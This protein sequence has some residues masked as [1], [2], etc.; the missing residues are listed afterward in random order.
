M[1]AIV[2]WYLYALYLRLLR[3]RDRLFRHRSLD[4]IDSNLANSLYM[5]FDSVAGAIPHKER[6]RNSEFKVFSQHGEDGILAYIFSDI[7]V[8]N[9]TFLEFGITDGR[10]CNTAN[11]SINFGWNGL[12]LE[13]D[14]TYAR[15]ARSYYQSIERYGGLDVKVVE[16]FVTKENIND[17]ITSN[18]M[19]GEIDLLSIDIDGNDYWIWEQ[20]DVISPRVVVMEYNASFGRKP[21]SVRYDPE[22]SRFKKHRSGWYHGASLAAL[23]NLGEKKGYDL[24]CADCSGVNGFFLRKDIARHKLEV[25]SAEEAFYPQEKRLKVATEEQQFDVIKHLEYLEM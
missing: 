7:G 23:A 20:I 18:G 22:F 4:T 3:F 14:P 12:L 6:I 16:C 17:T 8:T 10:E 9:K 13:G 5:Q 21:I 1:I 19:A 15:A 25:L 24:V 11:L 2:K